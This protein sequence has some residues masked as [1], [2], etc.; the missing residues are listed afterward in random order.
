MITGTV[1]ALMDILFKEVDTDHKQVNKQGA[2][3]IVVNVTQGD[4][5]AESS[6]R[7]DNELFQAAFQYC[8][9]GSREPQLLVFTPLCSPQSLSLD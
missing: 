8:F 2:H 7:D 1:S 6:Y 4:K 3:L 5:V 9:Q